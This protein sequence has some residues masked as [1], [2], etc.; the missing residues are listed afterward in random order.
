MTTQALYLTMPDFAILDRTILLSTLVL[1]CTGLVVQ[2]PG[3]AHACRRKAERGQGRQKQGPYHSSPLGEMKLR[4]SAAICYIMQ[5]E[6][7]GSRFRQVEQSRP[8]S[9]W[10]GCQGYLMECFGAN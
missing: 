3:R 2:G 5:R 7:G 1:N 4:R 10:A 9:D 6:D 8:R